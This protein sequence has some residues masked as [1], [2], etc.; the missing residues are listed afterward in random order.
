PP[1]LDPADPLPPPVFVLEQQDAV[2]GVVVVAT[3]ADVVEDVVVGLAELTLERPE[4]GLLEPVDRDRAGLGERRE[5]ALEL[6]SFLRGIDRLE[7]RRGTD[8]P[9][10]PQREVDLERTA[11]LRQV[12]I[13]DDRGPG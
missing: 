5:G 8:E 1:E 7:V 10:D 2:V 12:E 11:R 6:R 9:Q 3:V 13:A 4:A